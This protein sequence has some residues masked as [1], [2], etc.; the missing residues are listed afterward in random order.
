MLPQISL[1]NQLQ[2][3]LFSSYTIQDHMN[4]YFTTVNLK[5]KKDTF[6]KVSW[7]ES[8]TLVDIMLVREANLDIK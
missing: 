6:L 4:W 5:E 3:N 8:I 2:L 1:K 7:G